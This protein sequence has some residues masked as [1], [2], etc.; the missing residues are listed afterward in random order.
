MAID[1]TL[2]AVLVSLAAFGASDVLRQGQPHF[3]QLAMAAGADGVEVRGE[4]LRGGAAE[5]AALRDTG[6]VRVHSSPEGLWAAD[7]VLDTAA[8]LHTCDTAEALGAARI[9][10]SIGGFDPRSAADLPRLQRLLQNRAGCELLIENDQSAS[11]GSLGALRRF[12]HA[13]DAAGLPLGMTFDIG[14][15]HFVGECPMQAAAAFAHRVSYVHCK[16]VQRRPDKWVA[17]PLAESAAPWR[18]MLRAMP[19]DVPWAIEYPLVGDGLPAAVRDAV[20]GLRGVAAQLQQET[21]P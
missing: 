14:N 2:P 3:T 15:W 16:G 9:K 10:M 19:A 8:L 12:F 1:P 18:A 5:L 21:Y 6:A 20:A 7:G 11:A 4:L 17:V 13:C